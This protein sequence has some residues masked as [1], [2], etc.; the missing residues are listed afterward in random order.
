MRGSALRA[1]RGLAGALR[2]RA[3][4]PSGALPRVGSP[5]PEL[6][7]SGTSG[8]GV[9]PLNTR[10]QIALLPE[11]PAQRGLPPLAYPRMHYRAWAHGR[12]YTRMP[13]PA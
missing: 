4:R 13:M 9:R 10:A 11:T 5:A 6:S 2:P 8:S 1:P 3:P 12:A 7:G